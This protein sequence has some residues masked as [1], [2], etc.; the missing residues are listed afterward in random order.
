MLPGGFSGGDEPVVPGKFIATTFHNPATR[1][2]GY[3]L[4]EQRDG[5]MLSPSATA[6]ALI[7]LGPAALWQDYQYHRNGPSLDIQYFLGRHVSDGI[8]RIHRSNPRGLPMC[9]KEICSL[10]RFPTGKAGLW[11]MMTMKNLIQ[12]WRYGYSVW[13]AIGRHP[14]SD[15]AWN[16]NGSICAV[17]VLP[18]PGGRVLG[19]MGH[20]ERKATACTAMQ[21]KDPQIFEAGSLF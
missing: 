5:L 13:H 18:V 9:G 6:Q 15:I 14:S 17:E 7:K 3:R 11:R 19:K 16:P 2:T 21:A 12:R 4:L 1:R 8:Y 10:S 20:T